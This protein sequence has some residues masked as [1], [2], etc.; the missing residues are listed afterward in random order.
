[1]IEQVGYTIFTCLAIWL[2]GQNGDIKKWGYV[3]GIAAAPFWFYAA[4]DTAQLGMAITTAWCTYSWA[5]GLWNNRH[6]F[7]T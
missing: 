5:H 7:R 4:Y 2:V 6:E 1:M 3:S